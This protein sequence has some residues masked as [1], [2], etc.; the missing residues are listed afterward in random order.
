MINMELNRG[1]HMLEL[2]SLSDFCVEADESVQL[3]KE[4]FL[5]FCAILNIMVPDMVPLQV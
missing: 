1:R 2:K 5:N 4:Y 3:L